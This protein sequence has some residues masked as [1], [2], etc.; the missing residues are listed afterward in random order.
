MNFLEKV[1][2]L[3]NY[4]ETR[5]FKKVLEG[6]KILNK[7]FPNHSYILNLSGL[8]YQGLENYKKAIQLFEAAL[9][10][11][12][13]NISAMNNLA[14]CLKRTEQFLRAEEVFK[15]ILNLDRNYLLVY[16]NYANFKNSINDVEEAIKLYKQAIIIARSQNINP[17]KFLIQLAQ[18]F[19]SL[20]NVKDLLETINDIL[21][22][23]PD[24]VLAHRMLSKIFKYS[25]EKPETMEHLE[26]VKKISNKAN[27]NNFQKSKISFILGKA[28]HDLSDKKKAIE[29][30]IKGNQ[31]FKK[32]IKSNIEQELKIINNTQEVFNNIKLNISHKSFSNKK[33][34]FICGMPRSGSTLIEQVISSH[35]KVYGSGE[36]PYLNNIINKNFL[37]KNG[38]S[39]KKIFELQTFD[40]NLINEQY[41]EILSSYKIKQ[42]VITDKAPSNFRWIGFIKIF[43]PNS[44]VIHCKRNAKDNCFS[45]FKND[46]QSSQLNW[47]YDQ[48][49]ISKYY[50]AYKSLMK[51]WH[52]KIPEFIYTVE[53]E[54][55]VTDSKS[56]TKKLLDFCQLDFDDNCFNHQNNKRTPIKTV[57]VTEARQPVYKTSV[58]SSEEYKNYLSEMF[59]NLI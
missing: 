15:K 59:E 49:D 1:K 54:K 45:L 30:F 42:Q 16:N 36:L 22:I 43:F 51:F 26:K 35:N 3:Q 47:T 58:N 32:E 27:L 34:I 2:V 41:F 11:D 18:A 56:E 25:T 50:N 28:Y 19:H 23:E 20:N 53:Y 4:Y 13:T 8:A 55:F 14:N 46:F 10:A 44:L 6:C 31:L 12:H 48:N 39:L 33:M 38:L 57:S 7:K 24:N 37:D 5:N 52:A 17:V 40:K 21:K 9:K 29:F